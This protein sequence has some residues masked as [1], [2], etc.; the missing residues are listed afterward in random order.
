MWIVL[1]VAKLSVKNKSYLSH[2]FFTKSWLILCNSMILL[3]LKKW[4]LNGNLFHSSDIIINT[5][6]WAFRIFLYVICIAWKFAFE[7]SQSNNRYRT[8]RKKLTI[9]DLSLSDRVNGRRFSPVFFWKRFLMY[10]TVHETRREFVDAK[11]SVELWEW[12]VE[13]ATRRLSGCCD[14]RWR[15]TSWNISMSDSIYDATLQPTIWKG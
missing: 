11:Q 12:I 14:R 10:H 3:K 7:N 13:G 1:F 5:P 2:A 15:E 9:Y 8:L 6:F 4:T